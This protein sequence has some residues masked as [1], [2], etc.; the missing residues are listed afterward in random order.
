MT[1]GIGFVSAMAAYLILIVAVYGALSVVGRRS[2]KETHQG[3]AF[4]PFDDR[5]PEERR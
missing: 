2:R 3:R 5:R 4:V 1:V